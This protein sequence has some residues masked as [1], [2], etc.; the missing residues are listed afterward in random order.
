MARGKF[1]KRGGGKRLDAQSAEEIEQRNQRLEEMEAARQARRAA[2]EEGE[3]DDGKGK[4]EE[5][6]DDD[7]TP[8][9]GSA[10]G[11]SS[12]S[13][14][15]PKAPSAPVRVTTKEEHNKNLAK[16]EAVRKRREEAEAKRKVEEEAARA[17]EMEQKA[18]L[19]ELKLLPDEDDDDGGNDD[20][21][22]DDA[23][24]KKKK[25]KETSIPK[26]SKIEIKKMKPA[27]MKDGASIQN[28]VPSE[29]SNYV[30]LHFLTLVVRV[31]HSIKGARVRHPRKFQDPDGA[32]GGLRRS[33]VIKPYQVATWKQKV[34][35]AFP[36][37]VDFCRR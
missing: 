29:P 24:G 36:T 6:A 21:N 34:T 2:E 11:P 14:G 13:S 18:K 26:L 31:I 9:A 17:L 27:Q 4:D 16:L 12:V 22:D 1:D 19:A 15:K 5:D 33:S 7:A 3:E 32:I 20:N 23:K 37:T 25:K 30:S 28:V 8:T 10:A 35:Y